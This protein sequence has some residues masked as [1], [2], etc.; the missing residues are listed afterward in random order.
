M[1]QKYLEYQRDPNTVVEPVEIM[2]RIFLD[3][4]DYDC[5]RMVHWSLRQLE[6][7]FWIYENFGS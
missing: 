1:I 2:R 3:M 7:K 6:M 4:K 5:Q